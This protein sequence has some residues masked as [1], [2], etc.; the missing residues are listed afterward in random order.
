MG[1]GRREDIS[2]NEE[3]GEVKLGLGSLYTRED[4]EIEG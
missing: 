1:Y 3:T 2:E 4:G